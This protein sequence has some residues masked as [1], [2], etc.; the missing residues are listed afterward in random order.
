MDY[1]FPELG[2]EVGAGSVQVVDILAV[3]RWTFQE[4]LAV[5]AGHSF[6]KWSPDPQ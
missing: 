1:S 3:V 6:L 2:L 5:R 4:L